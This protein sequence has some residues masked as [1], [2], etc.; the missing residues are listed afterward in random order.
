M[1]D[2]IITDKGRDL[3]LASGALVSWL[4]ERFAPAK[5]VEVRDLR[6]PVGAGASN[7]TILFEAVVEDGGTSAVHPL[8]LRVSPAPENQMFLD[9]AFETQFKV[10]QRLRERDLVKVPEVLW[11]DDDPSWFGRPFFVMAQMRGRVPVSAPVYNKTGW[12]VD[13]TPEQRH[14]VWESALREMARIHVVPPEVVPFVSPRAAGVSGFE[15]ALQYARDHY[16]WA[17]AGRSH[18][19]GERLYEW[20]FGNVP[21]TRPDDGVSWGDARMGNMMFGDDYRLV[22][23]MDWEQ[24]SL[25]GPLLDLGWW[26]FFDD[27]HSVGQGVERLPGLGTRQET[28]DIWEDATGLSAAG[29]E[30]YEIFAALRVVTLTIR[31]TIMR[32]A[33][34]TGTNPADSPF[35]KLA[36]ERLGWI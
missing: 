8:V 18:P 17:A 20:V 15:H 16:A 23:V 4:A 21:P 6:Y 2:E 32:G 33:T 27:V 1:A 22:G 10:L 31:T 3:G 14:T 30:W 26:L 24:V 36:Y 19:V 28:I 34:P 29:V 25:G 35:S 7:E 5:V 12:L 11:F 13:A 9:V